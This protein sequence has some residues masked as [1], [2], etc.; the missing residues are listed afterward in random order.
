MHANNQ[1][2]LLQWLR[3]GDSTVTIEIHSPQNPGFSKASPLDSFFVGI[4]DFKYIQLY[5][6]QRQVQS[7]GLQRHLFVL[8]T[9]RSFCKILS[10][11]RHTTKVTASKSLTLYQQYLINLTAIFWV[12]LIKILT[13][14][15]TCK[16]FLALSTMRHAFRYIINLV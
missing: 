2:Q 6:F 3:K 1:A 11:H 4:R 10:L 8:S 13:K 15:N 12:H 16:Y 7:P 9:T 14:E 5:G